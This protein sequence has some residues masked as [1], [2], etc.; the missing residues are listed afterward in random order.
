MDLLFLDLWEVVQV[1]Q[2]QIDRYGGDPGIRDVNLLAS[3]VA[4]P[5][6]G[7]QDGYLHDD[8]FA[9]AAAYLFHIVRDHPFVDGNKRTGAV[10]AIV[11][12][13]MNDV[14][15]EADEAGLE[16]LVRNVTEGTVGKAEI[17]AFFRRSARQT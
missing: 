15:I 6:A 7:T 8:V 10:A 14:R 13:R 11:F 3:A 4:T 9:M 5:R 1:H 16:A 17:A 2:D 12:L